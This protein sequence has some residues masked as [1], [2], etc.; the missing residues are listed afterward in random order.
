[1]VKK[2]I[3]DLDSSKA[4]G[5]DCVQVDIMKN[6]KL[7]LHNSWSFLYVFEGIFFSRL[8]ENLI[9]AEVYPSTLPDFSIFAL[10]TSISIFNLQL[11]VL[12]AYL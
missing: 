1:M 12:W 3:T 7:G 9:F 11:R 5:Y 6:C 2:A 8:I 10:K 4:S